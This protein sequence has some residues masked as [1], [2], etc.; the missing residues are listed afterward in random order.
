MLNAVFIRHSKTA[1]NLLKRYIGITDESLCEEGIRL[2][3]KRTYPDVD[4]VYIS[5]LKRCIETAEIIY[6]NK[7][8]IIVDG[9]KECNFGEFEN[10]NYEELKDNKNYQEWIDS[11]GKNSFPGGEDVQSFKDRCIDTYKEIIRQSKAEN[12]KT[13]GIIAHGGTI[14]SVMEKFAFPS[15]DYYSWHVENGNGYVMEIEEA[16]GKITVKECI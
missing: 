4:V 1:S 9:L 11:G 6:K 8:K 15:K 13:I 3:N 10:K 5:P 16:S 14:M 7:E 12:Y 2:L